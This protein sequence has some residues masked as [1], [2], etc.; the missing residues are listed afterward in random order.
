MKPRI[1]VQR[2]DAYQPASFGRDGF[3]R[4][5][6]NENTTGCSPRVLKAITKS[7]TRE[8]VA[9]YP[10]YENARTEL[11]SAFGRTPAETL[12]TNGIDGH[13]HQV[14]DELIGKTAQRWIAPILDC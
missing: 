13:I 8:I 4:L 6:S 14:C 3:L 10:E 11:A 5:D 12:M 2:M 1:A 7:L 9:T